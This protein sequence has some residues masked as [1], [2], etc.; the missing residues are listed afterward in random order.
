MN[1]DSRPGPISAVCIIWA[2]YVGY[3]L[4][5]FASAQF[6]GMPDWF[7]AYYVAL[8]CGQLIAIVGFW[9][10][11]KWGVLLFTSTVVIEQAMLINFVGFNPTS[12]IPA[13][14]V[15]MVGISYYNEMR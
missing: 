13:A 8:S 5:Y 12:V 1:F 3:G 7:A 2:M 11:R 6:T 15:L 10:M 9:Q 4:Y 14:V